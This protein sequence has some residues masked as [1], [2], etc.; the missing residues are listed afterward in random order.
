MATYTDILNQLR[1]QAETLATQLQQEYTRADGRERVRGPSPFSSDQVSI[2]RVGDRFHIRFPSESRREVG[3]LP[4]DWDRSRAQESARLT[5]GEDAQLTRQNGQW[6]VTIGQT[7]TASIPASDGRAAAEEF[8]RTIG[9]QENIEAPWV[10]MAQRLNTLMGVSNSADTSHIQRL[11][12]NNRL[13]ELTG[14]GGTLDLIRQSIEPALGRIGQE[15]TASGAT[16]G[17]MEGRLSGQVNATLTQLQQMAR[18]AGILSEGQTI[19]NP[20]QVGINPAEQARIER[21][22]Q[23]RAQGAPAAPTGTPPAGGRSTG[24]TEEQARIEQ[25]E[26]ERAQGAP[27][28]P[29]TVAQ[30]TF[31][32]RAEEILG[33][34][35]N[36]PSVGDTFT[37]P[38]GR[39]YKYIRTDRGDFRWDVT[40]AQGATSPAGGRSVGTITEENGRFVV[41][42]SD[43]DKPLFAAPDMDTART[44]AIDNNL[45]IQGDDLVNRAVERVEREAPAPGEEREMVSPTVRGGNLFWQD[46][47]GNQGT[48]V[49]PPTPPPTEE[50]P[51]PPSGEAPPTE[52]PPTEGEAPP[53][54]EE[55]PTELSTQLIV[56][57]ML[58]GVDESVRKL[59]GEMTE[60][61]GATLD[62]FEKGQEVNEEELNARFEELKQK[63]INPYFKQL[64]TNYQTDLLHNLG[65][66]TSQRRLELE[67]QTTQFQEQTRNAKVAL[68]ASGMTFS[69]EALRLLGA[70]SAFG[71]RNLPEGMEQRAPE[72]LQMEEI[73][74]GQIPQSQRLMAT[75]TRARQAERL[76]A[77]ATGA[78]RYLG[79]E[80]IPEA[81]KLAGMFTPEG[82]PSP[83]TGFA[84]GQ[85]GEVERQKRAE[86]LASLESLRGVQT[87]TRTLNALGQPL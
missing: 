3:R 46:D 70:E 82:E 20:L 5:Y 15:R 28:A 14:R 77:L 4:A 85:I 84:G 75:S 19:D 45:Q 36:N 16:G 27:A 72:S 48:I 17:T 80:Q 23:E 6:V 59:I 62:A 67:A 57:G 9:G 29:I 11:A 87:Q 65:S 33:S 78:E 2:E 74:E 63:N 38:S 53:T 66:L 52:A 26:Q 42:S 64:I 30:P 44:W 43:A 39:E 1:T 86:E 83:T 13:G 54:G 76:R 34:A 37:A 41:R 7:Q 55:A 71:Q 49:K 31:R 24:T 47:A 81:F 69:G 50:K 56:D 51:K 10:Q 25:Q 68:E 8:A 12:A 32:E 40:N 21:Q 18:S 60:Q 22:E 73:P 58:Q 79:S 35:P 61:F